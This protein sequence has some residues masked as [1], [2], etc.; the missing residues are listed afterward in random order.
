MKCES[1]QDDQAFEFSV[2]GL[3]G[4][5]QLRQINNAIGNKRM[6]VQS[7]QKRAWVGKQYC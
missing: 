7:A 2:E 5:I 1:E 4:T 3:K 6:S